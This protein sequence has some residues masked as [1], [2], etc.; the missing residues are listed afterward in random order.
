[1]CDPSSNPD[2]RAE[3]GAPKLLGLVP[4]AGNASRISPL[5]L[6][7]ELFPVGFHR[8]SV[9]GRAVPKPVCLNLLENMRLAGVTEAYIVLRP[10]KWDI[11]AY[12]GCGKA[13]GMNL[14]YLIMDLPYG[15]PFT[16]DQAFPFTTGA[17]IAF[18]FPD[19]LFQPEDAFSQLLDEQ[20]ESRSD[21]VLGLF[22]A[23]D[24]QKMDMVALDSL[25]NISGFE[26]KPAMTDLKYTWIIAVWNFR[27]TQFLNGYVIE[28][29][30]ILESQAGDGTPG[31]QREI[32][33]SE[34]I[35]A[36]IESGLNVSR[37]IFDRGSC[38]DVGSPE[39]LAA[40]I[41]MRTDPRH[42]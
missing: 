25:G 3:I 27:F 6:S 1:M 24:P 11:P 37:V 36:A 19:I 16:L 33:M 32:H 13:L 42:L 2:R 30:S 4:A 18:G 38:I 9:N 21:V 5:P 12:L 15:V 41:H 39:N 8:L 34:V 31:G 40:A 20:A 29:L 23:R 14:G 7:K 10:G 35:Q 26:I 22:P 17:T 28:H